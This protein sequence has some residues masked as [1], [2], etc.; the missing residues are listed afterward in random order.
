VTSEKPIAIS[1]RPAPIV[2]R[3]SKPV[4]GSVVA[5]LA[6]VVAVGSGLLVGSLFVVSG[7][8]VLVGVLFYF[9][10]EVPVVGVGVGVAGVVAG[11][12]GVVAV[13]GGVP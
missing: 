7:A 4:N 10:G 5:F 8:V 9:D 6:A 2:Q 3:R 11:A 1:S 13:L 12:G